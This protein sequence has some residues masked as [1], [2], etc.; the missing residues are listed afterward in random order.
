MSNRTN[1]LWNFRKDL[2]A[3]FSQ[4]FWTVMHS[5]GLQT[6]QSQINHI[7]SVDV[8]KKKF[9]TDFWVSMR[10]KKK[11]I[12][13]KFVKK[14]N[15]FQLDYLF[16]CWLVKL[17]RSDYPIFFWR[18]GNDASKYSVLFWTM[19]CKTAPWAEMTSKNVFYAFTILSKTKCSKVLFYHI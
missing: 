14:T 8:K 5:R 1:I 15:N 18:N 3:L 11:I 9:C 2:S 10:Q 4:Y 12:E 16:I 17:G 19:L 6:E 7:I 13:E